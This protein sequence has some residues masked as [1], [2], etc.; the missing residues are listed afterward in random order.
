MLK[1]DEFGLLELPE[2]APAPTPEDRLV[3]AYEEIAEFT[4]EHGR[5]P[6][7]DPANIDEFKLATRLEAICADDEQRRVLEAV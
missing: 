4:R 1:E 7:K 5:P 2:P 3:A 6:E